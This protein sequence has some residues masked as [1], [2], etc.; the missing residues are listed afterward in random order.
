VWLYHS[1]LASVQDV[2]RFGKAQQSVTVYFLEGSTYRA[3][4]S[5]TAAQM[6]ADRVKWA[7]LTA[8]ISNVTG[9]LPAGGLV[10]G[11]LSPM[12]SD[13]K[14]DLWRFSNT[15]HRNRCDSDKGPQRRAWWPHRAASYLA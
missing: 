4:T 9:K 14:I 3:G 1:Q 5:Q 11:A 15:P 12:L 7:P 6:S 13:H 2:Q 10:L 8:G